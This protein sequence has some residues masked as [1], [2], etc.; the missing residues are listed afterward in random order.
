[1]GRFQVPRSIINYTTA[2][3]LLCSGGPVFR[4]AYIYSD[5]HDLELEY[6]QS[7]M[8]T[9]R[10]T[11]TMKYS[12]S[13]FISADDISLSEIYT[14]SSS[15]HPIGRF[16]IVSGTS[17]TTTSGI[18]SDRTCLSTEVGQGKTVWSATNSLIKLSLFGWMNNVNGCW[19]FYIYFIFCI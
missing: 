1:M 6:E 3:V 14:P 16:S 2:T 10:S 19:K 18:V 7:L 9:L 13:E 11:S 17:S 5:E 4:E 15:S 12:D 8:G